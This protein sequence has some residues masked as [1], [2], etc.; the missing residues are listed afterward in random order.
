MTKVSVHA[1]GQI[2]MHLGP[3]N[4][5]PFAPPIALGDGSWRHALEIRFLIGAG[6]DLPPA[7]MLRLKKKDT[8]LIVEVPDGQVL[9]LNLLVSVTD[10][11]PV[12]LPN[13]FAGAPEIWRTRL[14]DGRSVVLLC[15]VMPFDDQSTS[16]LRHIR[17]ELQPK[18]NFT[19]SPPTEP[20]YIEIVHAFWSGQG[21]VLLVIP[22]GPEARRFD[23]DHADV[24]CEAT[25]SRHVTVECAYGNSNLIAPDGSVVGSLSIVGYSGQITLAKGKEVVQTIGRITLSVDSGALR[26]GESF[27][28]PRSALECMLSLGG[29]K[30]KMW[31]YGYELSFDGS[32]ISLSVLPI[33]TALR[34]A[35]AENLVSGLGGGEEVLIRAPAAAIRL[36]ASKEQTT[37]NAELTCGLRLRDI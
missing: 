12:A 4:I 15:R 30:P 27:V 22:M 33:S 37:V 17:S 31:E 5:Q 8:A 28:R 1:S 35:N 23:P 34:N 32:A 21:N 9:Y 14:R 24:Q 26:W 3:R 20:P 25:D 18:A 7:K 29:A 2:H 19:G 11:F 16:A 6:A 10:R 13:E 36:T